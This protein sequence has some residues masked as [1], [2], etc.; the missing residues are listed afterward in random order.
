MFGSFATHIYT[1]V[2][3]MFGIFLIKFVL[4]CAR[5]SYIDFH[6][7]WPLALHKLEPANFFA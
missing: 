6:F 1:V 4:G 2:N 7:P 5:Q 3:E